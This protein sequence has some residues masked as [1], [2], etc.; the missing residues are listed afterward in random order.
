MCTQAA[1]CY[2]LLNSTIHFRIEEER[3]FAVV[4]EE[5][6]CVATYPIGQ[7]IF[8]ILPQSDLPRSLED[9]I[10][11]LLAR[12]Y[13]PAIKR[14]SL[15]WISPAQRRVNQISHLLVCA[16]EQTK[17]RDYL[18]S[19][20]LLLE[21]YRLV[22]DVDDLIAEANF[23][24]KLDG[25]WLQELL[26]RTQNKELG[27]FIAKKARVRKVFE[28]A[29]KEL[30]DLPEGR[31]EPSCFV[32]FSIGDRAI[33][34]WL[35]ETFVPDLIRVGINPVVCFRDLKPG[36][37]IHDFQER[38]RFTD[39]AVFICTED[40]KHKCESRVD[41]PIGAA[42]E[43]RLARERIKDPS[44]K[45][46]NFLIYLMEE[47]SRGCP[48]PYFEGI[49]G[50]RFTLFDGSAS[51][52]FFSYYEHAFELFGSMRGIERSKS[53]EVKKSFFENVKR[54]LFRYVH[55]SFKTVP[56]REEIL[57]MEK[58]NRLFRRLRAPKVIQQ[59][60][61]TDEERQN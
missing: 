26:D 1:G 36:E 46:T 43:V 14:G 5:E 7:N 6:K 27:A 53:R 42:Q 3:G 13:T 17:K 55:F 40:L 23:L 33:E 19:V 34:N 48:S 10:R 11:E 18:K 28:D 58:T 51:T 45:G 15:I 38:I 24:E 61:K 35:E 8:H 12:D 41:A 37:D 21:A 59:K 30:K 32:C 25:R 47:I 22:D 29:L 49:L 60:M 52:Q 50:T 16:K 54:T 20:N 4:L 44:K 56:L 9:T 39:L 31:K 2:P 57:K